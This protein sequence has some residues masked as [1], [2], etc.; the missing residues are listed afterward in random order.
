MSASAQNT[1][2]KSGFDR[3]ASPYRLLE[4]AAFGRALERA[5]FCHFDLLGQRRRRRLLLLGDGDGRGLARACE[6]LPETRIDSVDISAGMLARAGR[7]LP[8]AQRGR[9][10]LHH[11]D[12]LAFSYPPQEYDAVATLFFLD[13]FTLAEVAAF[14]AR[15]R[16]A[17]RPGALWL[18]ADFALPARRGWRRVRAQ[19]WLAVM[20]AFFRWQTG[21]SARRLPGSEGIIEAAGLKTTRV[22]ESQH[23]LLRSVVFELPASFAGRNNRSGKTSRSAI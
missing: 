18:H 1:P 16:P 22:A 5:R 13:C 14:V 8:E 10:S 3:L 20:Y 4:Y 12:A 15:L 19:A 7:R 6:L 9:V 17:L 23:G 11:A 21:L 2:G